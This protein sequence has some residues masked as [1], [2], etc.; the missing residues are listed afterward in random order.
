MT[1]VPDHAWTASRYSVL[2]GAYNTKLVAV[3]DVPKRYSDL[4]DPMW[5]GSGP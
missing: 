5:R 2:V 4:L 1:P 3:A